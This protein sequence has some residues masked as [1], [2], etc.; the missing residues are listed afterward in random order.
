MKHVNIPYEEDRTTLMSMPITL[1][2]QGAMVEAEAAIL[3]S[4]K[5]ATERRDWKTSVQMLSLLASVALGKG[6]FATVERYAQ[7]AFEMSKRAASP[8]SAQGA[9]QALIGAMTLQGQW[10]AAAAALSQLHMPGMSRAVLSAVQVYRPLLR[11]YQSQ[12]LTQKVRPLTAELL[13]DVTS[14][15]EW[16]APLCGLVELGDASLLSE[17][18]EEPARWLT[19]AL[20][21]GIVL[22][23]GWVFLVPRQLGIAAM[24]HGNWTRAETYFLQAIDVATA[25]QARPELGRTYLA[26]ARMLI[27]SR[28]RKK[29]Q[30]IKELL[31]Q[32]HCL[33]DALGMTP[34]IPESLH[35][36]RAV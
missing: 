2:L 18:T 10:Q 14:E 31:E 8:W 23:P 36:Q 7:D 27:L 24:L 29:T 1:L 22:S 4:V 17:V 30:R 9:M 19:R 25:A 20:E 15:H 12:P 16:L 6:E 33:F 21:Q 34:F 3:A 26:Y 28:Q 5:T 13:K 11:A 32:A 35:L